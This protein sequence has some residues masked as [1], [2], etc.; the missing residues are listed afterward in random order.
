[1]AVLALLV[2]TRQRV[3]LELLVEMVYKHLFLEHL[4][5]MQVAVAHI[6]MQVQ[7]V[8]SAVEVLE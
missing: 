8:A 4:H 1:M 2:Q 6:L 3:L 5:T 7:M